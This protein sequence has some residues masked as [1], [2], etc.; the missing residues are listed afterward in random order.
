MALQKEIVQPNGVTTNYHRIHFIQSI[1]NSDICIAV[2]SY[3]NEESRRSDNAEKFVVS[4]TYDIPDQENM[5]VEQ[6]Y[7]YLKTLPKF[8]GAEDV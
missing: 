1:I 8:E 5:T 6:A 3:L 7:E 2:L 4:V